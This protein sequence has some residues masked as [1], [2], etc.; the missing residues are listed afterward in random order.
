MVE[1]NGKAGSANWNSMLYTLRLE[2]HEIVI[3]L[4]YVAA[5]GVRS[6]RPLKPDDVLRNV[7]KGAQ[8]GQLFIHFHFHLLDRVVPGHKAG[9][10]VDARDMHVR[11]EA[12]GGKSRIW[13]AG[14]FF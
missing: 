10:A 12:E 9:T 13:H 4:D 2:P 8:S 5:N 7:Y 1:A 11:F 3:Y 6:S 14:I